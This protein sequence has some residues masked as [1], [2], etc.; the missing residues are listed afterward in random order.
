MLTPMY[1]FTPQRKAAMI[2]QTEDYL[3]HL[4]QTPAQTPCQ[5][6]DNFI[7]AYCTVFNS[8]PPLSFYEEHCDNFE[9]IPF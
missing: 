9:Y 1:V 2:A 6:C 3:S 5:A 4:K 7:N 8:N